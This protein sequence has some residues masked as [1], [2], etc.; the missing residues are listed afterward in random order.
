MNEV[1]RELERA[2]EE[3][4]AIQADQPPAKKKRVRRWFKDAA[5]RRTSTKRGL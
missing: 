2:H 5:L 1:R 4:R 3:H